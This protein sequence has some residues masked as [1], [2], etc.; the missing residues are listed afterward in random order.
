MNASGPRPSS[1][2]LMSARIAP[3]LHIPAKPE[4][5][6]LR[7]RLLAALKTFARTSS[8]LAS[9]LDV[10]ELLVSQS[11]AAMAHEGLVVA[12]PVTPEGRRSQTWRLA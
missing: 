10:K 3:T 12:N 5:A 7:T 8:G 6:P 2:G 4:P 11:L 9:E 1:Y